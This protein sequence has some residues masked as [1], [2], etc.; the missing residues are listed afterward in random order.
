MVFG[1]RIAAALAVLAVAGVARAD[2]KK[3]WEL[4]FDHDRPEHYSYTSP[5]GKVKNFW[6]VT[7]TVTNGTTQACPLIVDVALRVDL[8]HYQQPGFW[9]LEEQTIIAHA[10]R[11]EGYSIGIQ[12]ELIEDFKKRRK[13]LNAS[14][15]RKITVLQPGESV[16]CIALFEDKAYRYNTVELLVSGLKDPVT[17]KWD[18]KEGMSTPESDIHL[19]YENA[20]FRLTYTREGD[21]FKSFARGLT[22]AKHDWIVVGV[23]PAVTKEDFSG[24]VA[25]LHHEDELVRRV[26]LNLLTR[27]SAA[28]RK[29]IDLA[30]LFSDNWEEKK[31]A[32]A[33]TKDLLKNLA[34][35]SNIGGTNAAILTN[36]DAELKKRIPPIPDEIKS[37][38]RGGELSSDQI[39][40]LTEKLK[41]VVR[42]AQ[43]NKCPIP[44][45]VISV[46]DRTEP[47]SEIV[48]D[49]ITGYKDPSTGI[50][51]CGVQQWDQYLTELVAHG[52]FAAFNFVERLYEN[53]NWKEEDAWAREMAVSILKDIATDDRMTF[54]AKAYDP[55]LTLDEQA[56][57][58]K[59]A[60]LR[61]REWWSRNRDYSY[62][63]TMTKSFEPKKR[64]EPPR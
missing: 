49:W 21:Q 11:M 44:S 4:Q 38:A 54:D 27:Y 17:Y 31:E 40:D 39:K 34:E 19:K 5:M 29:D 57:N 7:Y 61:W 16:H 26:A 52:Q 46:L 45:H 28:A 62:W 47:T 2:V 3:R 9:P 20:V 42:K 14:D 30:G 33:K 55:K 37:L 25:A 50:L 60:I 32:W 43:E 41:V 6:Y 18:R 56:P 53:L 36:L 64:E 10:D 24:L 23:N 51:Y 48:Y 35:M 63:N 22:L 13:Y 15:Q 59:D 1:K 12:K 58:V 8:K